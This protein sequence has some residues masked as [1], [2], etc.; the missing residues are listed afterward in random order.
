LSFDKKQLSAKAGSVT[1]TLTNA[2]PLEHNMTIAE[3]SK[4]LG[5]TPTFTL[6][7]RTVTLTLKAGSYTFYCSVPG[8]RQGGMEG[9]L[10]VA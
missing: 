10:S 1:I 8:H 6:G 7:A 5:A 4:V 9:T 3:G 2:S